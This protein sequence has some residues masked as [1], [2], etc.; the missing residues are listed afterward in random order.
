[1]EPD[2]TPVTDIMTPAVISV[3]PDTSVRSVVEKL[4]NL[5]VHHLFVVDDTGV[6]IGVISPIDVLKKLE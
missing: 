5:H 1:L 4:L 6:V 2:T 3:R